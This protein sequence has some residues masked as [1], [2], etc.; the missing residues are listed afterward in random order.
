MNIVGFTSSS[1]STNA[2]PGRTMS[3]DGASATLPVLLLSLAALPEVSKLP[4]RYHVQ[5]KFPIRFVRAVCSRRCRPQIRGGVAREDGAGFGSSGSQLFHNIE[6]P[7]LCSNEQWRCT[8]SRRRIV[9]T[10]SPNP[11]CAAII[12]NSGIIAPVSAVYHFPSWPCSLP[13]LRSG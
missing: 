11:F 5:T 4:S 2:R 1:S 10:A 9:H 3:A 8:I 6:M 12:I 7:I 13:P